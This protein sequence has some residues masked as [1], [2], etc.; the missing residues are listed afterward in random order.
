MSELGA[1]ALGLNAFVAQ[2]LVK[3]EQVH[4]PQNNFR[5]RGAAKRVFYENNLLPRR[6]FQG[7]IN[8]GCP[9]ITDSCPKA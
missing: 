8:N 3:F 9:T 6:V 1:A 2:K 5:R 7:R 4:R